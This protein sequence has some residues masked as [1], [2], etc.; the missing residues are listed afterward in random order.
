MLGSPSQFLDFLCKRVNFC[1]RDVGLAF[2]DHAEFSDSVLGAVSLQLV[3]VAA[4]A[5]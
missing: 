5:G 1:F 2:S 3:E 4:Y